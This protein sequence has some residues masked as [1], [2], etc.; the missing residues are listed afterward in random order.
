MSRFFSAALAAAF[1]VGPAG[2]HVGVQVFMPQVPD[3]AAMTIDGSEDDWGWFDRSFA[4]QPDQIIS[5]RGEYEGANPPADDFS[6]TYFT[7]W[8]APPDNRLYFFA[9]VSDDTLRAAEGADRG[10]W[11]NDDVVQI[12]IDADHSGGNYLGQDLEQ[13][14]NGQRYEQAPLQPP[15]CGVGGAEELG[16]VQ[17]WACEE[18]HTFVVTSVL[19][20]DATNLTANVEY[21][22][23]FSIALWDFFSADGGPDNSARHVFEGDQVIHASIRFDD[24]DQGERG[25]QALFGIDGGH[26]DGDSDGNQAGDYTALATAGGATAVES[27]SW[28]RM[29]SELERRLRD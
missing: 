21:T 7:A 28:G 2:A 1:L 18:P 10:R 8:S 22:Y 13:L 5:W 20:A 6:A 19:P 4:V 9:R 12:S 26:F 16:R 14:A 29:K 15:P 11:W 27:R 3:P 25:Q 24:G 23:E 17:D